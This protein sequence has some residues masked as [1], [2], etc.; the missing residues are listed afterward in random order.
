MTVRNQTSCLSFDLRSKDV[1]LM[2]LKIRNV[3]DA[4]VRKMEK[5]GYAHANCVQLLCSLNSF[6]SK[7]FKEK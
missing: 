7:T 2:K 1:R 5:A 3:I 6:V 4:N